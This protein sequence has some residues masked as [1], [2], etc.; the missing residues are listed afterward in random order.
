MSTN[1][2]KTFIKWRLHGIER[3][4]WYEYDGILI[5]NLQPKLVPANQE[6]RKTTTLIVIW[7]PLSLEPKRKTRYTM[8]LT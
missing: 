3:L 8:R 4:K 6:V 7:K 5:Q 1:K 2:L